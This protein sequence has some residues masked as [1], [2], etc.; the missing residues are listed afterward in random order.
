MKGK[1]IVVIIFFVLFTCL[2]FG[3]YKLVRT[4]YFDIVFS[5]GLDSKAFVLSKKADEVYEKLANELNCTLKTRPKVYLVGGNDFANGYA[6]PLTNTIVI[7]VN[8]VDPLVITP[9]YEDWVVFC[10][11]HELTHLFLMNKLSTYIEPLSIFGQTVCVALQSVLTPMYLHEGLATY[12]E[13]YL[14]GFGRGNDPL[15]KTYIEKAKETDV[16]LRYASSLTTSRWLAGGAS[17]VQGYSLLKKIEED[18]SHQKVVELVERFSENPL[19]P[20]GITLKE[21]VGKEFLGSWLEKD[22][23]VGKNQDFSK[24][25]LWPSKVDLNA[26]RIYYVA[27]KY[28]SQEALY[29]CDALS[30]EEFKVLDLQNCVSF[31]VSKSGKV[32]VARYVSAGNSVVSQLYVHSGTTFKLPV[33][34]IVDLDWINDHK[35]VLI[36]QQNGSR[37]IDVYDLLQRKITRI[38]GP[39]ENLIPLQITADERRIIFT[40]K[41]E[42]NIGLFMLN[43]DGKLYKLDC[44][45][46]AKLS[47]KL[48]EDKLYFCAE[49]FDKIQVFMLDLNDMTLWNLGGQDFV[50]AVVYENEVFGVQIVPGGYRFAS[51]PVEPSFVRNLRW[52]E[53][54]QLFPQESFVLDAEKYF[55]LLKY[56]FWFP[57]GYFDETGWFLGTLIGFWN[58]AVDET[59][60]LQVGWS[61]FGPSFKVDVTFDKAADLYFSY[62]FSPKDQTL[63]GQFAVP[64]YLNRG[65]K[66]EVVLTKFGVTLKAEQG[67]EPLL[68][69]KYSIGTV[70]GKI[71]GLSVPEIELWLNLMPK[72][73]VGF[74]RS[75]LLVNSLVM[76]AVN[77]DFETLKY[78]WNL[79]LPRLRF[80]LGSKDGF[81]N[82]DGMNLSF[83]CITEINRLYEFGFDGY[84]KTTFYFDFLYQIPMP[85]FI[86]VGVK[87]N[88]PYFRIGIENILNALRVRKKAML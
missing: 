70:G 86:M 7:Y 19:R 88:K 25:F 51:Q 36:R 74:S 22:K 13:T 78:V 43:S 64:L 56:R 60:F 3:N 15:F 35:L 10:F 28:S 34:N 83:G 59:L 87:D 30:K 18:Y 23:R 50:S 33:Q 54:D 58:D 52:I 71:H 6:N 67:F 81:W 65:L 79:T 38:F 24:L 46:N 84:V 49:N 8:D 80:N 40:G 61:D 48:V 66:N 82:M 63:N 11:V 9:N 41:V 1:P 62:A 57:V 53:F 4:K 47:P 85:V 26:W 37:F 72:P 42:T 16:G 32:A 68:S 73:N 29:Y 39:Y 27:Q 69:C 17:Y 21:T 31:S 12:F 76:F 77:T 44:D 45:G 20:F 75:F 55:D 14:T 5:E 2:V